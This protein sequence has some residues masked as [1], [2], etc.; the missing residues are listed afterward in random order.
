MINPAD[1]G[2]FRVLN[3][4]TE[5]FTVGEL[6]QRV[7]QAAEHLGWDVMIENVPNPRVE[8]EEHYYNAKHTRLLELGLEPHFL[9]DTLIDHL[10]ETVQGHTNRVRRD[11][12]YPSHSWREGLLVQSGDERPS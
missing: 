7:A 6:A 4:F 12:L 5:Q 8:L 2:E 9:S 11:L 10:L 1:E 3:Q